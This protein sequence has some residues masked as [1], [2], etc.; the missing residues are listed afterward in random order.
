[1]VEG[2]VSPIY[3]QPLYRDRAAR[4]SATRATRAW[5]ATRTG[6]PDLRAHARPR[7]ALSPAVHAGMSDAD[8][9]DV[10]AAFR[11]VHAHRSELA[12]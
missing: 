11:K 2:Y 6:V 5:A 4:R 9:D 8:V 12:R 10:I 1:M 7:G 3:R